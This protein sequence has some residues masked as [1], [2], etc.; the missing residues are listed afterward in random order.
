VI[1]RRK[2]K[3]QVPPKKLP[4]WVPEF[5]SHGRAAAIACLEEGP[6]GSPNLKPLF[7]SFQYPTANETNPTL[8]QSIVRC[9]APLPKHSCRRLL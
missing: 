6:E 4:M 2:R 5:V 8:S 7:P 3:G 1:E 9:A